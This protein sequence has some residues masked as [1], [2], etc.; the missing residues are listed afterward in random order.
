MN[1]SLGYKLGKELQRIHKQRTRRIRRGCNAESFSRAR[2]E[3]VLMTSLEVLALED[4]SVSVSG[5][6]KT[7]SSNPCVSIL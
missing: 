6:G 7:R 5:R 4:E 1:S 2:S 3:Y